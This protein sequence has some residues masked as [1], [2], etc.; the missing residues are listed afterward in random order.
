MTTADTRNG[1]DHPAT[2]KPGFEADALPALTG[3]RTRNRRKIR[4]HGLGGV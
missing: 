1:D 3:G 4:H 2:G